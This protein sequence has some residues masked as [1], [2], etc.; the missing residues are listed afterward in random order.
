MFSSF[1]SR[2]KANKK[3]SKV[4]ASSPPSVVPDITSKVEP[5]QIKTSAPINV[6]EKKGQHN[7]H[8][9]EHNHDQLLKYS[10]SEGTSGDLDDSDGTYDDDACCPRSPVTFGPSPT[11]G[12]EH[13][14]SR[15]LKNNRAWSKAIRERQPDFFEKGS[16]GQQPKVFWIGCSDSRVPENELLQLAPGEVFTHRNIANVVVSTDLNCLSVLQYAV[17][18]LKVEHVVVCGHY[19]CGGVAA[20]LG[21][22]SY[23]LIDHWLGNIKEVK[24]QHSENLDCIQDQEEKCRALVEI[25]CRNSV[26]TVAK[27][28]IMRAAWDRGQEVEIIGMVYDIQTGLLSELG[29]HVKN[30]QD[31]DNHLKV[32]SKALFAARKEN[33]AVDQ[34]RAMT[35][36]VA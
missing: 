30:T 13:G 28:P 14:L 6:Q 17:E 12:S 9:H 23:G 34:Q 26:L 11:V 31:L 36:T 21:N 7:Y 3:T 8:R 20:A 29:Y 15:L 16:K 33:A 4:K 35:K 10:S 2:S 19:G 24:Q 18:V 5:L 32:D 1:K 22:H 25:N 27:S